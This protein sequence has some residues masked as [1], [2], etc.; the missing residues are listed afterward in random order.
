LIVSNW[1][2]GDVSIV[3]LKTEKEIKRISVG[4]APRGIACDTAS[5]Y[6]Y[7]AVMGCSKI[8]KIN[9]GTYQSETFVSGI[10]NPRH[11]CI[12]DNYLYASLNGEGSVCRINLVSA[13]LEKLAVGLAPRS[14]VISV[15]KKKLFV[16]CYEDSKVAVINLSTFKLDTE[17]KT[18]K[19]PIGICLNN[20]ADQVWVSCYTGFIQVFSETTRTIA[21]NAIASV[22]K[23][24]DSGK[25]TIVKVNKPPI[26]VSVKTIVTASE[27]PKPVNDGNKQYIVLGS[28]LIK[29]NALNLKDKLSRKG[30]AVELINTNKG[31][32]YCACKAKDDKE[33][34]EKLISQL[35]ALTG[36]KGWVYEI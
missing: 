29:E 25:V 8:C 23:K 18:Y 21:D 9:L 22:K 10:R 31:Y 33:E 14:M 35:E 12:D 3:D 11:L 17:I 7:V 34:T 5:T 15:A 16:D 28:F 1:S 24:T 32:T 19:Y 6:A 36:I 27:K 30:L 26:Q 4:P 13:K 20:R 2:S